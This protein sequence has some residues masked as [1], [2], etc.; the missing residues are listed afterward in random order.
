MKFL[1][2]I[3][4]NTRLSIFISAFN[5][6][7]LLIAGAFLYGF[8]KKDQMD[9]L[10]KTMD[11]ELGALSS[12]YDVT[13]AYNALKLENAAGALRPMFNE[14][15][16]FTAKDSD[17]ISTE[18]YNQ[19]TET[20]QS[21]KLRRWFVGDKEV[22]NKTWL[23][24]RLHSTTDCDIAILQKIPEG[25]IVIASS[26]IDQTGSAL[27]NYLIPN[28][29]MIVSATEKGISYKGKIY[30]EGEWY[31]CDFEPIQAT[32]KSIG[33]YAICQKA[34]R[35]QALEKLFLKKRYYTKGTASLV[36]I[37]GNYI[38]DATKKG[39]AFFDPLLFEKFQ[40]IGGRSKQIE[41]SA[42][43]FGSRRSYY[44][45]YT[46]H[47]ESETYIYINIDKAELDQKI[48]QY[49]IYLT[50]LFL[51]IFLISFLIIYLIC[52]PLSNRVKRIVNTVKN[53]S[54]GQRVSLIDVE[55]ANEV[56]ALT[57]NLNKIIE[58]LEKTSI[59]ARE[60]GKGNLD[61]DYIALSE[62]DMLGNSLL[63]MRARMSENLKMQKEHQEQE[64]L[65]KWATAGV[66]LFN[67]ILRTKSS[68]LGELTQLVIKNFI[69]YTDA[70]QGAIFLVKKDKNDEPYFDMSA[71][72]AYNKS[73]NLEKQIPW[74]AGLI[75][76]AALERKLIYIT[77]IPEGYL[78]ITS[79]LG[80]RTPSYLVIVALLINE[81]PIGVIEL[82]SLNEMPLYKRNFISQIAGMVAVTINT[83]IVNQQTSILLEQS[84]YQREELAAKEEVMRRNFEELQATQ[85]AATRKE[86]EQK[87]VLEALYQSTYLV[88]YDVDG[89][90][91]DMNDNYADLLK[92]SKEALIGRNH[93]ELS[94][95]TDNM[96]DYQKH[97]S[98]LRRNQIRKIEE[99]ITLPDQRKFKFMSTFT[100]ILDIR[101]VPYKVLCISA[102][103][104]S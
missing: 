56:A 81:E 66:S 22:N 97:W 94:S 63:E 36:D 88:E 73:R 69:E 31:F 84:Q 59:M 20:R 23:T 61:F 102:L 48:S 96:S 91:V 65:Q 6:A 58:S 76:R 75:G 87:G 55:G 5:F 43:E 83:V 4:I 54:E 2:Q 79:G 18:A 26:I 13:L 99:S 35:E 47:K 50:K 82:A 62:Q 95:Y 72:Y 14:I 89:Y 16:K 37:D 93:Q 90:I 11:E 77:D 85:E 15:I 68:N 10:K 33:M 12:A 45:F 9:V 42:Y 7:T 25:F 8:E 103:I 80:E 38:I 49:L 92:L 71:S 34:Y 27:T 28:S 24:D 30:I 39:K 29:S 57:S 21:V 74:G 101:Q 51:P 32:G 46:Y 64:D 98:D 3:N 44:L 104:N 52:L 40:A 100:P 53:L 86:I 41:Y 60:I 19:I 78:S 1:Q 67:D 17:L 70:N